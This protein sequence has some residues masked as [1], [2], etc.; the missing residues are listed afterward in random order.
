MVGFD[1]NLNTKSEKEA[2]VFDTESEEDMR[3]F[4]PDLINVVIR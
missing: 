1:T 2:Y 3:N 4:E